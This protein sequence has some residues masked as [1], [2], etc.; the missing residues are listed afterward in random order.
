MT[1][2]AGR[3]LGTT[4]AAVA[5][6]VFLHVPL[7]I[8]L[9]ALFPPAEDGFAAAKKIRPIQLIEEK[10]EPKPDQPLQVVSLDKPEKEEVPKEAKVLDR[11][12]QKV[13]KETRRK[14]KVGR[15]GSNRVRPRKS[16]VKRTKNTAKAPD[17]ELPKDDDAAKAS[18]VAAV[19]DSRELEDADDKEAPDSQENPE[20]LEAKD[21]LPNMDNVI[22]N[23]GNSGIKDYLDVPE[24]EKD[25][26]NR[27]QT[28][29][30]SFFDRMK[31]GVQRQWRPNEVYRVNDP[32]RQVYGVQ[33]RMTVLKV[34]LAGD[35]SV[36]RIIIEKPSGVP[37]LD[38]E[39]KRA[40]R[41]ASPFPN[42]PEGLKD[43]QG[44]ISLR[45]GFFL[46]IES[47]GSR[48]IRFRR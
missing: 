33:D 7:I 3:K 5:V 11:Y 32:R 37:F 10:E 17:T 22:G 39:A 25:L 47:R 23:G 21:I 13:E 42:P 28:R 1:S 43:D 35:G 48:I 46:D 9:V 4:T 18:G 38:S 27:K 44:L 2:K 6:S 45:F 31:R 19:D 34:T 20:A 8:G 41:A 40:F 26:I 30:W 16:P 24:G 14:R 15:P 29:Y 36:R 12:N